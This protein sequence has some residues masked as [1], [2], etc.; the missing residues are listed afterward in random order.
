MY[1]DYVYAPARFRIWSNGNLLLVPVLY[2]LICIQSIGGT[3]STIISGD[4]FKFGRAKG[5]PKSIKSTPGSKLSSYML[6]PKLL[7]S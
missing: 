2:Q 4:Y 3:E 7:V 6:I 1:L 5:H